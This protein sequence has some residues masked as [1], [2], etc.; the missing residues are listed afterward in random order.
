MARIRVGSCSWAEKT[1]LESGEFYPKEAA[2]AEERLR[3]YAAQ[4]DTVE[5]DTTPGRS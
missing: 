2:S 5:V 4:F 1:L 3:F